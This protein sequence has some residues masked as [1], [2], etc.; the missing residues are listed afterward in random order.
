MT[1][2]IIGLVALSSVV[3]LAQFVCFSGYKSEK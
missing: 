2:I 3:L 1:T